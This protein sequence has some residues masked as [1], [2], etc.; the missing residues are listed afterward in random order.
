MRSSPHVAAAAF[1]G[2]VPHLVAIPGHEAMQK[3]SLKSKA[4]ADVERKQIEF[5]R[6]AA[7]LATKK[8]AEARM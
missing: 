8:A 1:Q 5:N 7:V 3:R 6:Q 4:D 2:G